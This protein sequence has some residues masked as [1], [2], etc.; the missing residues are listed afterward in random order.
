MTH[1]EFR[2]ICPGADT[3]VLFI[4]G[5]NG[6]PNHF[7]NFVALVPED[8]SVVNV[9]LEGHG[10]GVGEFGKASM[11]RWKAQV[12]GE[13][14]A[15]LESHDHLLITA[16]SMGTLFAIRQAVKHPDKVDGLFLLAAPLKVAVT[17]RA[18]RTSLAVSQEK[19]KE[20]DL[21]AKAA[22]NC[23]GIQPDR[24]FWK[25]IPW[26]KRYLELFKE[27]KNVNAQLSILKTP[28]VCYQSQ[29]D[30]L[31]SM[32]SSDILQKSQFVKVHTLENSGHFYYDEGDYGR[33][34]GDFQ[35]FVKKK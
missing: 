22:A 35:S 8:C 25:Y 33:V 26:V 17:P 29:K 30:E 34:L 2:K 20:D 27:I 12:D 3:A 32:K 14:E 5:I 21:W 1:R 7:R 24:R 18:I 4:H 19:V 9:L 13:V 10:K 31:V 28:C 6:T 11:A 15:L 16:H 23:Y